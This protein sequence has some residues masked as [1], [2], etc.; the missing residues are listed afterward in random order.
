MKK[1]I[2]LSALLLLATHLVAQ[3]PLLTSEQMPNAVF[4][5]PPPPA[6]Q[7]DAFAYDKSQYAWGKQQRAD[8]ARSAMAVTDAVWT[9]ETICNVFSDA[10]GRTISQDSTPALFR[11]LHAAIWTADQAGTLPK[12]HYRRT[13]PYVYYDEPSLVPGDEDDLRNNGSYPSGHTIRGWTAAL[14]LTEINP[15]RANDILAR[16]YA[17]GQ[18]RVIAGYHWQSDVD[19]GRLVASAAVARLHADQRFR[20]LIDQARQEFQQS[21]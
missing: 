1:I 19:A 4:F 5:L 12:D 6:E 15:L 10:F 13:R 11:L 14:L 20:D 7:S 8:S 18:S 16:G 17:F 2:I 21:R 9:L 3:E